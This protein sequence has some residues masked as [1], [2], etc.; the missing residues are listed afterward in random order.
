MHLALLHTADSNID[1][2][3]S[4]ARMLS[5]ADI[6]LSHVVRS[7]LLTRA[8][9]AGGM[10]PEILAETRAVLLVLADGADAVLLTCS[11]LGKAVEGLSAVA[12][13]PVLRVDAALAEEAAKAGG[14]VVVLCAVETTLAPTLDLFR[15]AFRG[16]NTTVDVCLVAGA[17]DRFKAGDKNGYLAMIAEAAD[18]AYDEG[19]TFVA[20]GQSSMSGAAGLVQKGR[21]PLTS[22]IAGLKAV[23]PFH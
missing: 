20:L 22:P 8:E 7:D 6:R 14:Q 5:V 18:K 11:T 16:S 9:Q 12:Q 1:V 4:S 17:W 21:I 15:Q 23:L 19:A 13:K 3:E 2:F 10:T